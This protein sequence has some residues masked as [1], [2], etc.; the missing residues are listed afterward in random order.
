MS[1]PPFLDLPS[2]A[3][4]HSLR[5]SRG[6]FA[7]HDARPAETRGTVL[8][9]P[10][11]TGSKEDFI[12]LLEP[13]AAAGYRAVAV[14]GRGQYESEGPHEES[15]YAQAELARDVIAQAEALGGAVHLVGH[16]FGGLVSRAA[17]VLDVS[18]FRSLTLMSCGP[19]AIAEDQQARTRLLLA[20]LGQL[21]RES[22]WQEMQKADAEN[23]TAEP[24]APALQEFLHRR[25]TATTTGQLLVAGRQLTVEPDRTAELAA[26]GL[27]KHVLSGELDYAWPVPSIDAMAE[28]LS[29]ARTVVA[30][31]GHSPN[32]ERPGAT[33][34]AL[35]GFWRRVSA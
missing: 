31:A 23:A 25:W 35:V 21:D 14:D 15:A 24:T 34:A 20:A 27:P 7:T 18:P 10:G 17:V 11:F 4:A 12:A 6:V 19:A 8:L 29:A 26:V 16:S 13:L 9:V 22:V 3:R 32:A 5:T 1:R 28:K 30:G 33:A 2:C